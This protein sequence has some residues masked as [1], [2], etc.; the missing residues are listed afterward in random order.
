MTPFR[1]VPLLLT[2]VSGFVAAQEMPPKPTEA[3]VPHRLELIRCKASNLIG[4]AITN[5][6]NESLGEIQDIVLDSRN[7]R[8]A[9]VVVAFGGTLGFGEKYFAMPWRLIEIVQRSSD[10]LPR[11]TLG[12]DLATLKAAPGFDKANWPDMANPSWASQV[13]QYY[14]DRKEGTVPAGSAEPKGSAKDGTS[15]AA[16]PPASA[17]FV[18]RRFSQILGTRVTD[19]RRN[20]IADVEDLVVGVESARIEGMLLSFGGVLGIGESVALVPVEAMTYDA[21]KLVYVLPCS[22]ERLSAMALKDGKWPVLGNDAW[23]TS[24]RE[25]CLVA[26]KESD[27]KA[28]AVVIDANAHSTTKAKYDL[29]KVETM[30]GTIVTV[31]TVAN[32][33]PSE[34]LVR[35]RI[36]LEDER[37]VVVH[38]GP[39]SFAQQR[40]LDLRPGRRVRVTGAPSVFDGRAVVLAGE[41]EVDGKSV[42][43]RDEDGAP[44]WLAGK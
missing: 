18:H 7:Q 40:L 4:C 20:R 3:A 24:S 25:A 30:R 37:E 41:L 27:A 32:V 6:K 23:L 31:G 16:Q 38:A 22:S 10:D 12:L 29:S 39:S 13:D 19:A 1:T 28:T 5:P 15:G 17:A 2:F 44:T 35:L 11:A 33:E 36:R 26:R 21:A 8:V 42:S 43:L 34:E 14:G 9:Y